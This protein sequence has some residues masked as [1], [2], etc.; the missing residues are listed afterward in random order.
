MLFDNHPKSYLSSIWRNSQDNY[1]CDAES[2][3]DSNLV[4]WKENSGFLDETFSSLLSSISRAQNPL[5]LNSSHLH[6]NS[7]NYAL[8]VNGT[9]HYDN[10]I[11]NFNCQNSF[12]LPPPPASKEESKP[13]DSSKSK[14]ESKP[15][16]P[17]KGFPIFAYQIKKK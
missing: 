15:F 9:N 16:I 3:D 11:L 1:S 7:P 10:E 13:C 5:D 6:H 2:T 8:C 14:E 17:S 12:A 4:N